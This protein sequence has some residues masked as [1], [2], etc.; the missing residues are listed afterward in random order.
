M[1]IGHPGFADPVHDSQA[2]FRAV[3]D[4]LA[5]PGTIHTLHAPADPPP[6]LDR[7]T[8]A[9]LLTLAD[10]DTPLWLDAAAEPAAPWIAFHCGA[11]R[12][13]LPKSAFAVAL[14]PVPL[15]HLPPGTDDA[16][17]DGAT[18]ILQVAALGQGRPLRLTGPG[19]QHPRTLAV[20]GLGAAF[21]AEWA[22]NAARFPRGIDLILCTGDHMAALPRT[23]RIEG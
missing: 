11:P 13:A 21:V 17:E 7:A 12:A 10:I 16:P 2:C 22:A 4:A 1:S 23:L 18:L 14:Q 6:P 3:L 5:R 19:L 8:A 15:D 20:D 9:V